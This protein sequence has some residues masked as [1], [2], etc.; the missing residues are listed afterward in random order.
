MFC[1]LEFNIL[2]NY[3]KLDT[4]ARRQHN[5]QLRFVPIKCILHLITSS[6]IFFSNIKCIPVRVQSRAEIVIKM[7]TQTYFI[8]FLWFSNCSL[9]LFPTSFCVTWQYI[10]NKSNAIG[11]E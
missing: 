1:G 10:A 3:I 6:L 4:C 2:K 9:S 8:L 5:S 11:T 7:Q